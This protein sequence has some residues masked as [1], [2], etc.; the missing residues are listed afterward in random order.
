MLSVWGL[1]ILI[2]AVML[3]Y[4]SR[5]S[6]D[7]EDQIFLDD[8][9]SREQSNQA[10]IAARVSKF[11]PKVKAAEITAGVATLIVVA[12]FL[13]DVYKQLFG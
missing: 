9:F 2:M 5:L 8:S 10:A 4:R 12:Y 6:R 11:Q 7:E 3:L 13:I 1:T